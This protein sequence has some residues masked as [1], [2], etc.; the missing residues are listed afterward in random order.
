MPER[1]AGHVPSYGRVPAAAC[2]GTWLVDPSWERR[3][4][5]RAH[6]YLLACSESLY[7]HFHA[8]HLQFLE[9]HVPEPTPQQ[10]KRPLHFI[11]EPGLENA[12]WPHLYWK[13]DMCE[14]YE[15]LNTRRLRQLE[16][17]RMEVREDDERSGE[18]PDEDDLDDGR[19]HSIKRSFQCKLLAP[20][21]GYGAEFEL[22]QYVFDLHLCWT[23][24]GSKRGVTDGLAMRI[25]MRG[26]PMSPL[27]WMDVKNGLHDLINWVTQTS[28]G[29]WRLTSAAIRTMSCCW[30]RCRS[31]FANACAFQPWNRCTSPTPC[32]RYV[33]VSSPG[34]ESPTARAGHATAGKWPR[35]REGALFTRV[36]FQDGSRKAGTQ[37]YHGSGRPHVHALFWVPDLQAADL[38]SVVS[39]TEEW[40]EQQQNL[41]AYVR[42]SQRDEAGDSRWPV[43]VREN[44][45]DAESQQLQLRHTAGDAAEG[46][47]GY[48]PDVM[49]SLRCHQDLQMAQGRGLLLAYVA[50]YVAKWSDSSYE[51]WF[52]DQASVTSLCR[53]VL[54]EYHPLEPEMVLQLT[55]AT[56]RQWEFGTAQGGCRSLRAPRPTAPVDEQPAIVQAYMN[57][58]WRRDAMCLL[59][60]LCARRAAPDRLRTGSSR[61]TARPRKR[62]P[63]RPSRMHTACAASKL[64]LQISCIG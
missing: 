31:C 33:V 47:G 22:L 18:E 59:E 29:P 49:D 5:G 36:E 26:H 30:T 61:N 58:R 39:A 38:P 2:R 15:H 62:C 34:A 11:E 41:A 24:L 7:E 57:S 19:R 63:W 45:F 4:A 56:F 3:Q 9:R 23:D 44:V 42:G 53:K 46:V 16:G 43:H 6:N 10:A 37:Q 13:A 54:F 60:F 50:K 35:R 21:L 25:M 64:S 1:A 51:E 40:P 55:Q 17:A 12:L 48:F 14:S 8:R 27:Y 28:T 32:G 20:L 52:S